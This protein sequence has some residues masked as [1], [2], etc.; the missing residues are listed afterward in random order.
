M[1]IDMYIIHNMNLCI[2]MWWLQQLCVCVRGVH[3]C[4]VVCSSHN[5]RS[6]GHCATLIA[7]VLV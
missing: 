4:A 1:F 6:N 5:E 3:L 2:R 7:A